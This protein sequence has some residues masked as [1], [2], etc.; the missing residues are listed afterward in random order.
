MSSQMATR[1]HRLMSV[2]GGKTD[3]ARICRYVANDPKRTWGGVDNY[4]PG[5]APLLARR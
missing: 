5:C 4:E 3:I 2:I 1:M